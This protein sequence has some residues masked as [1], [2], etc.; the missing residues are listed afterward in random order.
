MSCAVILTLS[1]ARSTDPSTTPSTSRALAISFRDFL[2]PL[3]GMTEVREITRRER[4]EARSVIS[5]S[6]I[7]SAKYSWVASPERLASGRTAREEIRGRSPATGPSPPAIPFWMSPV[8]RASATAS[9]A[10]TAAAAVHTHTRRDPPP[11]GLWIAEGSSAWSAA[12]TS[13]AER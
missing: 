12:S 4:I 3:K 5:S 10:T 9:A 7:P 13:L 6:V 2:D 1:P 8:R 11:A